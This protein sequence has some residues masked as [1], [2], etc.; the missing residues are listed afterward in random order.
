MQ[1]AMPPFAV[2]AFMNV[3]LRALAMKEVEFW[4]L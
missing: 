4:L 2:L 1:I 3:Q